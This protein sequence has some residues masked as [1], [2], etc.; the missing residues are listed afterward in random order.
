MRGRPDLRVRVEDPEADTDV[1]VIP[2]VA[3]ED[4][5]TAI[6]AEPFLGTV[7]GL[8]GLQAIL[9]VDDPERA[10]LDA[11]VGGRRAPVR[12]WQRVQWQ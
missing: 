5:R 9:A 6:T 10:G 8:P 3:A 12:R 4:V 11:S 2:G 7:A 1:P